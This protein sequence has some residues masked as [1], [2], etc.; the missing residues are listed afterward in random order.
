MKFIHS[1]FR[2]IFLTVGLSVFSV[3]L[4][5]SAQTEK[6]SKVLAL[7]PIGYWPADDESG[8]ILRDRSPNENNGTIHGI[9]W[10]G[11]FL[12]F[13]GFNQWIQ[14][15]SIQA[16]DTAD[17]S[18]SVWVLS[19]KKY[20]SR[21]PHLFGNA[22]RNSGY[23]LSTL[24][25]DN[26]LLPFNAPSD[27]ISLTLPKDS[28]LVK[29]DNTDDALE[30]VASGIRLLEGN[31]QHVAFTFAD[32]E[33]ILYLDG[34]LVA[35]ASGLEYTA[36]PMPWVIGIEAEFAPINQW[37]NHGLVG[38]IRDIAL[39]DR[40]L[41]ANEVDRLAS[42]RP[43]SMKEASKVPARPIRQLTLGRNQ[44]TD[45]N[46]G[47]EIQKLSR[48]L[49]SDNPTTVLESLRKAASM[50]EQAREALPRIRQ[51]A[52]KYIASH[53]IGAL[54]TEE[55]E[56]NALIWALR[57][58]DPA[59]PESR[60]L[61]AELWA[62]PFL[63]Q[64]DL[65]GAGMEEIAALYEEGR[66]LDAVEL[67]GEIPLGEEISVQKVGELPYRGKVNM[68][69]DHI[70]S[71]ILHH[72]GS[73][74]IAGVEWLTTEEKA[75]IIE[76][77]GW[78]LPESQKLARTK[79]TR[80]DEDGETET[81]TL[82][83]DDFIYAAYD[84]KMW[85]WSLG[86]DEDGY[87]H[88]VGGLHNFVQPERYVPGSFEERGWSREFE[89]PNFPTMMYWKS[90]KPGDIDTFEFVGQRDNPRN[91]PVLQGMNYMS[92]VRDREG[93]LFT[94][95]RIY[96]QGM[97][98]IGLYRY[99]KDT[100]TW[101]AL[102]GR[103]PD[104]KETDPVW[105]DHQILTGDQGV[106]RSMRVSPKDPGAKVLFWDKGTSWYNFSRGMI[107]FDKTNRMHL[108]FPLY[109]IK[110]DGEME[111]VAVYAYSDDEGETFHRADG[112]PI[113]SLPITASPGPG[114]GDVV[115][116]SM[117]VRLYFDGSGI[118]GISGSEKWFWHLG[119]GDW[120]SFPTP[121]G[122]LLNIFTE[123]SGIMTFRNEGGR[124]FYR[125]AGHGLEGK[126][127]RT[128]G[129]LPFEPGKRAYETNTSWQNVY[130]SGEWFTVQTHTQDPEHQPELYEIEFKEEK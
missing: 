75:Q 84:A 21:G 11:P 88:L 101:V 116:T 67:H 68:K 119:K 53:E 126:L 2:P 113:K 52:E 35:S 110:A 55:A 90:A 87:L 56:R 13:T 58:I 26:P 128:D 24:D 125:M 103:A 19:K 95:G 80:I 1:H 115:G 43:P 3:F 93:N 97:Q 40:A 106:I 17:V 99:D 20:S 44:K 50:G 74:Y 30:S 48:G 129:V 121:L 100:Q 27:G 118:P 122:G 73:T 9:N 79:I 76:R 89:D 23:R 6:H 37:W 4:A 12:E 46:S 45:P 123:P 32:G 33:G 14:I 112:S 10:D 127:H 72:D 34:S 62:K 77:T 5:L 108:A 57:E 92:F 114:Q 120:E 124:R 82:E 51:L 104:M 42:L 15:E 69:G 49:D 41:A 64:I 63:D 83:G 59:D 7:N 36:S 71:P 22:Y 107:R 29:I 28:I 85:G 18:I 65:A 96:V 47:K 61:L 91:L 111:S 102:G 60:L 78:D 8:N 109:T 25:E 117:P 94:Y 86:V 81:I 130:D 16:Y 39:F 70:Y 98:S 54:R 38:S 31:W 105:A 66:Y